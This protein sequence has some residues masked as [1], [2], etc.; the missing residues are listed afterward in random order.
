[1]VSIYFF[2]N[3]LDFFVFSCSIYLKICIKYVDGTS[4]WLEKL[5]HTSTQQ[6]AQFYSCP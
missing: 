2:L 6:T 1:M 5:K 3:I 4:D